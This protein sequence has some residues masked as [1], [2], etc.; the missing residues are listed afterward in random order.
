MSHLFVVIPMY[1]LFKRTH[2]DCIKWV[3]YYSLIFDK[4]WEDDRHQSS[5]FAKSAISRSLH[6]ANLNF[7]VGT[8]FDL[9]TTYM[10]NQRLI[11]FLVT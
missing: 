9:L 3:I 1:S 11:P 2:R 5:L 6:L 10:K 8:I 4:A 7:Q